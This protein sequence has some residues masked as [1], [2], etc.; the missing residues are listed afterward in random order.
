[1]EK[2][3]PPAERRTPIMALEVDSRAAGEA[4]A[5]AELQG[6]GN[7]SQ[8]SPRRHREHRGGFLMIQSRQRRDGDWVI[9]SLPTGRLSGIESQRLQDTLIQGSICVLKGR[10]VFIWRV[11]PRQI[12]RGFSVSSVPLW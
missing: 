2:A 9:N 8:F 7:G 5:E 1:M 12:K 11:P 3:G 4:L 10:K 6:V